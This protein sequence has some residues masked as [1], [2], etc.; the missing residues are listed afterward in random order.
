MTVL[1]IIII[2]KNVTGPRA[3]EVCPVLKSAS[4]SEVHV[5]Y[6][7]R[8]QFIRNHMLELRTD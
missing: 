1:V 2:E 3:A 6:F 5:F 4:E 7:I 8:N